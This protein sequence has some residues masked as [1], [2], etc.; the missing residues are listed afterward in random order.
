M[1]IA[2]LKGEGGHVPGLYESFSQK[3]TK[4]DSRNEGKAAL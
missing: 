2:S 1:H 3:S 4:A